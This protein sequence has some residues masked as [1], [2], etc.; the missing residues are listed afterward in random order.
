MRVLR[1]VQPL[2]RSRGP[3]KP[4]GGER[5]CA[6]SVSRAA[7]ARRPGHPHG[8]G[9]PDDP[10]GGLTG[11]PR[12]RIH[13]GSGACYVFPDDIPEALK[14][15]KGASGTSWAEIA[16]NDTPHHEVVLEARGPPQLSPPPRAI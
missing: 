10:L 3:V 7:D 5:V 16:R 8:P 12:Q 11:T 1:F 2:L 14:R 4:Q 9:I 15:V 13:H 6:G